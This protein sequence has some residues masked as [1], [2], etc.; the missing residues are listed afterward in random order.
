VLE[1]SDCPPQLGSVLEH[2][3]VNRAP[4]AIGSIVFRSGDEA[5]VH[6]VQKLL[7]F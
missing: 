4:F 5:D 1:T 2:H 7:P 3:L 6:P